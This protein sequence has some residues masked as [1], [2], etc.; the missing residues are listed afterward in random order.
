MERSLTCYKQILRFYRKDNYKD[1]SENLEK[2]FFSNDI[3][4]SFRPGKI[5][6]HQDHITSFILCLQ[7]LDKVLADVRPSN[8][9]ASDNLS[10]VKELDIGVSPVCLKI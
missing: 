8:Y 2:V 3:N 7:F 9:S 6:Q 1:L 5:Y 4:G 10:F